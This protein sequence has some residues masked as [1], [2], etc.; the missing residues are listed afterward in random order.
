MTLPYAMVSLAMNLPV[1]LICDTLKRV[2]YCTFAVS[3]QDEN[4]PCLFM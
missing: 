3:M 4:G 1:S 2:A